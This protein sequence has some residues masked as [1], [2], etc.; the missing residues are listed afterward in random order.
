VIA[1][2]LCLLTQVA[3]EERRG[4]SLPLD[5]VFRDEQGA[6]VELRTLTGK[7]VILA[8]VYY[9]CPSL[10]SQILEALRRSLRAVPLQAGRD[11][12]V[13]AVSFDPRETA[14]LTRARPPE[15][16]WR[17]LTGEAEPVRR[18]C[19]SVGFRARYDAERDVFEHAGGI[20]VVTPEGRASRYFFGLG[21]P[22]RDVRLALVEAGDGRI[23][24]AADRIMLLCMKYDPA[25]GRY[26]LAIMTILR[27]SAAATAI[28]LAAFVLLALR[29]E[30]RKRRLARA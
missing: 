25:T 7:P 15:P 9:R 3:F 10:C 8:L 14:E 6:P 19:E 17:F 27:A 11:F 16:G 28:G 23:G 18:L 4:E 1:L 5:A 21:Y 24:S 13:L 2:L 12:T 22:P 30:R 20:V 29:R 26:G